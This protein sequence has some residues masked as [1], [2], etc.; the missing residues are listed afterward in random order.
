MEAAKIRRKALL[1]RIA[2]IK[3]AD[4]EGVVVRKESLSHK[5]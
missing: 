1:S 4:F 3:K 2:V 5:N